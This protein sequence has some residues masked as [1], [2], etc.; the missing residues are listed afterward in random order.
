[1]MNKMYNNEK[2]EKLHEKY[3][4]S[5]KVIDRGWYRLISLIISS[6]GFLFATYH[7]NKLFFNSDVFYF[8]ISG[9]NLLLFVVGYYLSSKKQE[10][11]LQEIKES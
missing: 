11:E 1:M 4:E 6:F 9:L 7:V 10:R 8:S 3:I 2:L 5:L